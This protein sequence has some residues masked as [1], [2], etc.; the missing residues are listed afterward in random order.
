MI[1]KL[2]ANKSYTLALKYPTG[3]QVEGTWGPQL[4]WILSTGDLLYTPLPV[5]PQI[6]KLGIKAGQT[7]ILTK[8]AAGRSFKWL[9]EL[10]KN[11]GQNDTI[12]QHADTPVVRHETK[13]APQSPAVRAAA[14]A[15]KHAESLG[16]SCRFSSADIRAMGISVLIS[17][18]GSRHA[19]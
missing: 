18:Q 16:Y 7:F 3:K 4:R 19:A 8:V 14:I 10:H 15:E 1:L 5:G 2:E 12:P 13:K 9:V 17:M 11:S 6:E